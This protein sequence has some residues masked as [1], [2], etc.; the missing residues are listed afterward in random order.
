MVINPVSGG[1]KKKAFLEE[2][3]ALVQKYAIDLQVFETS[4]TNDQE[5]LKKDIRSF[6]PDR[7]IAAGGDGTVLLVATALIRSSKP[8][9]VVPLG[10]ANGM[11]EEL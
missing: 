4:G 1:Q 2:T 6:R 5:K 3:D 7:L 10:S 8:M 9:G 11:A